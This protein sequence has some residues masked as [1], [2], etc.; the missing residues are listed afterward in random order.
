MIPDKE[1]IM[2]CTEC[3]LFY[4]EMIT[5]DRDALKEDFRAII[6]EEWQC[7]IRTVERVNRLERVQS[8]LIV[9]GSI[10]WL[11]IIYLLFKTYHR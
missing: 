8:W 4:K 2:T 3:R 6:K 11:A 10:A 1:H 5:E 7:S 9:S